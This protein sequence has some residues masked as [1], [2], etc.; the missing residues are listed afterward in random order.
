MPTRTAVSGRERQ[1]SQRRALAVLPVLLCPVSDGLLWP[2]SRQD[3]P[4]VF[5]PID[6]DRSAFDIALGLARR[7]G[8]GRVLVSIGEPH[9]F[10]AGEAVEKHGLDATIM[11]AGGGMGTAEAACLAALHA[12]RGDNDALLALIPVG[13]RHDDAEALQRLVREATAGP[14][15]AVVAGPQGIALARAS[16]LLDIIERTA[17]AT[18]QRC[19]DAFAAQT[20]DPPFV[21]PGRLMGEASTQP[22]GDLLMAA[23]AVSRSAAQNGPA[24]MPPLDTVAAQA[25]A[26][27]AELVGCTN[28]VVHSPHRLTVAVGLEN[29]VIVDTPDALLVARRDALDPAAVARRIEARPERAAHRRVLRPWGAFEGIDRGPSHQVK[30]ITVKPGAALSLQY[31]HHRAEHWIVVRGTARVTCGDRTFV[32]HENESTFIPMGAVHRLENPGKIPLEMIEVQSGSYLG[33]D[34][35]VRIEDVYGR[36]DASS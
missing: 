2:L 11:L 5:V 15:S 21:R 24:T 1:T 6:G 8:S 20:V 3:F 26:Q 16:A 19:R 23:G 13:P 22:L 25:G 18:I 17:P 30:H 4:D 31:H 32:L 9:R 10:L 7:I 33:E 14:A 34:D 36:T 27:Q 29:V 12:V 35:I 28:T